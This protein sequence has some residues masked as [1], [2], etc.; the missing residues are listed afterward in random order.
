MTTPSKL[1]GCWKDKPLKVPWPGAKESCGYDDKHLDER[2][3]GCYDHPTQVQRRA[4]GGKIPTLDDIL[5][6]LQQTWW[7]RWAVARTWSPD[8]QAILDGRQLYSGGHP[9]DDAD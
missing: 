5:T 6:K 1:Y 7:D 4:D 8:A 3:I 9:S 2:C